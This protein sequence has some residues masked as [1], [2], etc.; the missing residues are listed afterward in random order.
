VVG[1]EDRSA[2][3]DP[4]SNGN[5]WAAGEPTAPAANS[6]RESPPP[7]S[8]L[9][10]DPSVS[11]PKFEREIKSY[12]SREDEYRK[13]GWFLVR[14]EYPEV[15]VL[16]VAPQ[17]RPPSIQYAV[18]L[19]FTDYDLVPPSLQFV[20]P[21]TGEA[22]RA[23]QVTVIGQKRQA[24]L[25]KGGMDGATPGTPVAGN[26]GKPVVTPGPGVVAAP[27]Q[28][29]NLVQGHEGHPAFL[30]LRGTR[31]YH[32]HPYH[33]NDPWLAHRGTG[34][35]TLHYLL[36]VIW[37]NGIVPM[38]AYSVQLNVQIGP[39]QVDWNRIP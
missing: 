35:G 17:L 14:A 27:F 28:I 16:M 9:L 36:N 12:R 24:A 18:K 23:N 15:F 19:N 13:R 37:Q 22:L 39:P 11:L 20:N 26:G 5:P 4:S 32:D 25:A 6:R 8:E 38:T 29:G 34:V 30:C 31:E 10:V 7:S 2:D 1:P 21:F 33:S 3:A